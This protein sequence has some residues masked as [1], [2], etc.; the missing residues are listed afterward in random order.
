MVDRAS[1]P[2]LPRRGAVF[3]AECTVHAL[4]LSPYT[5]QDIFKLLLCGS[6]TV[7]RGCFLLRV[8]HLLFRPC[9]SLFLQCPK[10]FRR[11]PVEPSNRGSGCRSGHCALQSLFVSPEVCSFGGSVCWTRERGT[12]EGGRGRAVQLAPIDPPSTW[13]T[14]KAWESQDSFFSRRLIDWLL[15]ERKLGQMWKMVP[16][17]ERCQGLLVCTLRQCHS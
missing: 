14:G 16:K 7:F 11:S 2:L 9:S 4:S 10:R 5:L 8:C 15:F 12:R 17:T 6:L 13:V 3:Y 1:P